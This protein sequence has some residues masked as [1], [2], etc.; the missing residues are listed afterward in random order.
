MRKA[1]LFVAAGIL[2]FSLG[3]CVNREAQKQA[4]QTEQIV[5]DPIKVVSTTNV[6]RRNIDE[7]LEITGQVTAFEDSQVGPKLGGK[8]VAVY[9]RDGDSVQSGQVLAS[10]DL[11]SLNAQLSQALAQQASAQS[12]LSQALSNAR[13][14]PL[15]STSSVAAATAQ[16]KSSQAALAKAISGARPEEKAQA[17]AAVNSAKSNLD[18]AKKELDRQQRLFTEGAGTKQSLDRAQNAFDVAQTAYNSAVQSQLIVKNQTRP[19]DL[20]QAREA[21]QA[22]QANLSTAQEQKKLDV[23]FDQQ[24]QAAQAG[25]Q[26]AMAQVALARQSISDAQIRAPFSGKISGK[27]I[28]PGTVVGAGTPIARVIGSG[29]FYFEGE[30]P[31]SAI[32]RVRIGSSV[33]VEVNGANV[34][35]IVA[36]VSPQG[37]QVGRIFTVRITLNSVPSGVLAGMFAKGVVSLRSVPNAVV[38]PGSAIVT[39]DGKTVVYVIENQVAKEVPVSIGIRSKDVVQVEGLEVGKQLVT[40]GQDQLVDGSKVRL[41]NGKTAGLGTSGK[42]G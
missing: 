14:G 1:T 34:K 30:V 32:S 6:Q 27:P 19:E 25:L 31:E 42:E 8:I 37:A 11:S 3:G 16:L 2:V 22:A 10:Q 18:T 24:V 15:K 28:Q 17:Q 23:L 33:N 39:K 35:G 13:V 7:T 12:Q 20:E 21:V 38:I 36:A 29:G 9:V 40:K 5:S 4:K 41:D 26:S